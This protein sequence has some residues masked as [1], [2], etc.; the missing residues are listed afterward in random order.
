M[1][2]WNVYQDKYKKRYVVFS[3][4]IR[5]KKNVSYLQDRYVKKTFDSQNLKLLEN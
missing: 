1:N 4:K 5:M 2:I 3:I